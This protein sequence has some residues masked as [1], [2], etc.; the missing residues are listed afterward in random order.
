[1]ARI[2]QGR[3][4]H[5]VP[6]LTRGLTD[7]VWVSSGEASKVDGCYF[8]VIGRVEKARGIRNLVDWPHNEY[9]LLNTRINAI[10]SFKSRDG[11]D[12]LVVSLSGDTGQAEDYY[13]SIPSG[14][15][16]SSA[17][18]E[19]R[20]KYR[21]GRVLLLRGKRLEN[22]NLSHISLD[23]P[24]DHDLSP[25][26]NGTHLI[27]GQRVDPEDPFGSDYFSEWAG[28]LFISNG[29]DANVKWNGSY[30]ARVGVQERPA[31][32]MARKKEYTLHLDFSISDEALGV[33][34]APRRNLHGKQTFQYRATFVSSSGAEGPPSEAGVGVVAGEL[35]SGAAVWD[36]GHWDV[37]REPPEG[38]HPGIAENLPAHARRVVI[39]ITG[40][41][42][43][44]Q[45][46]I[47]WRNI[48]K[49][50]KDG[51]Y[52]FW[53]QVSVNEQAVFD[54]ED[55]LQ[56]ASMGSP[57]REGIQAPPTSKFIGFFRG[58]G[59]YVSQSFPSFVFY[60]DPGLPEQLSSA[61]QYLD[62]NSGD[63]GHVTGLFPFGDSLVVFK[64]D[65]MWQITALA[66][67]SPLLTPVDESIGSTSPRASILAYERLVFV[68][69]HGVYQYDGASVRPLSENLNTWWKNVYKG[70][71]RTAVSWLDEEERRLFIALQSGPED[72]NDM[73]V[74]YH[75]QLDAISVVGGQRIT[76]VERHKGETVLGIRHEK[77]SKKAENPRLGIPSP[78]DKSKALGAPKVLAAD[79]ESIR[80]SDLV[81]WGLGN[82]F[83]Y[84]FQPGT[85]DRDGAAPTVTAG[86]SAGKIRFGPY[87]ANQT[88]W[89]SQEEMEVAGIDVF[90]PYVGNH[91]ATVRWYKNRNP[92]A[93]GSLDF[94]L[95]KDGTLAQKAE[96]TDLTELDGWGASSKAWDT[97]TWNGDRQ[98][99]QRIV[100]PESVVCRE[101][102]I[103]F[104]NSVDGEPLELDGFVLW[105]VSKG[106][107]R[108]R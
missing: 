92:V 20:S 16:S 96:N 47:V 48:Y 25:G 26:P 76:A 4:I 35:Y 11:V 87:S 21:G 57:L 62:V 8:Q 73:V 74:C 10:R 83:D 37:K 104:E 82:S 77:K 39:E 2:A 52:Y 95:N 108:Q 33:G 93:E 44:T 34:G 1:V 91:S 66:D 86:S 41:D 19:T 29:V 27:D 97:S 24:W 14:I 46:D 89:N 3:G 5:A 55:V 85:I 60:S 28:W 17:T 100:F 65:S 88:G 50:S 18:G 63:G 106:S 40:L 42:R 99:F 59:Y 105:R 12:E 23:S 53:R 98:L 107:E 80:N 58:R 94:A 90:F 36:N 22:P 68:G 103:E 38:G 54:T 49:R 71:L 64:E 75:Y 79:Q 30:A 78:G 31:P 7:R 6:V 72:V 69:E 13:S 67:G 15:V 9:H 102:E 70:G 84:S 56:S 61:L 51:D 45:S 81:L 32:P 43:P 101:I